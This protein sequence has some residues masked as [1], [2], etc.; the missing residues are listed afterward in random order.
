MGKISIERVNI[1][2]VNNISDG[3]IDWNCHQMSVTTQV[4]HTY[5]EIKTYSTSQ[6]FE[7]T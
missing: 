3:A 2:S 5:K 1:F 7:Y 6:K 4:I